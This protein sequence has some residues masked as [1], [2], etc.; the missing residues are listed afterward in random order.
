MRMENHRSNYNN[1]E[2]LTNQRR[3]SHSRHSSQA[4]N[5]QMNLFM[6]ESGDL[7]PHEGAVFEQTPMSN[8]LVSF[9]PAQ[10]PIIPRF[11]SNLSLVDEPP[12]P[13]KR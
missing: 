13:L 1:M 12:S 6:H 7:V 9:S 4:H 8:Q 10:P 5:N 11:A 3:F 2:E